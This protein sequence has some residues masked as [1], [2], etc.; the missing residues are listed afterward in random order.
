MP[1]I[2]GLITGIDTTSIIDGLLEIQS[3]QIERLEVRKQQIVTKQTAFA[4]LEGKLLS[5][6]GALGRLTSR[7]NNAFRSKSFSTSDEAILS[8]AAG[9]TASN[10]VYT[11]K[12]NSLARAH[13]VASQGFADQNAEVD[14]GTLEIKTATGNT[15]TITI[16]QT[17]NS[18]SGLVRAIND[19]SDD[20]SASII[21]DG[22]EQGY[23][24]LLSSKETGS[25]GEISV[26]A[27]LD[28]G[29]AAQPTW[30]FDNPIQEASSAQ[31]TLGTGPGAIQVESNTNKIDDLIPGVTLNLNSADPDKEIQIGVSQDREDARASVEEFVTAYNDLMDFIDEQT[32]YSVEADLANP[33][34]GNRS[35]IDIQQEVRSAVVS[36]VPGVNQDMNRLSALG[37]TVGN[38]GK[39][40]FSASKFDEAMNGADGVTT[41]DVMRLFAFD[42]R[43]DKA[44]VDFVLGSARSKP[45]EVQVE[46]VS[47]AKAASMTSSELFP[48]LSIDDTND[49]VLLS[50][51]N[52][53]PVEIKLDHGAFDRA[54]FAAAFQAKVNAHDDLDGLSVNIDGN[55]LVLAS[56][57]QGKSSQV[58][59]EGSGSAAI[60]FTDGQA[61]NGQDVVGYFLVNGEREEARSRGNLLIGER[62][63]ENT[64][65]I[66]VRI[67]MTAD[68]LN[69]D[70]PDAT[71]SMTEGLASSLDK[72][73]NDMLDAVDGDIKTVND[74]FDGEIESIQQSIDR[75]N[76]RFETS[77][78]KLLRQFTALESAVGELQTTSSF[79]A[80]QLASVGGLSI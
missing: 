12:V 29:G 48:V 38:N 70:G 63:N 28:G 75:L 54:T 61:A 33:L 5:L 36:T 43:S 65:D 9:S 19:T 53:D 80:G 71:I 39:L 79:I 25:A 58:K 67:N 74:A 30:D 76:A 23:R 2:D 32:R 52:G 66:Q 31:V 44:G 49:T 20:V 37:I 41:D 42:G 60:G 69:E 51:N 78:E 6:R 55:S 27:N 59:V 64:A 11:V 68:Q 77:R 7:A 17:N 26:T 35:A 14:T 62:D 46:V 57:L 4:G 73:L 8:G 72:I 1:S 21:N 16:D 34:Q 47:P 3:N 15:A 56:T 45:G 50:L 10:G 13:Q 18:L 40:S 24:I 22:S